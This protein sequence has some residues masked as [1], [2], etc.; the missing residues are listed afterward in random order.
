MAQATDLPQSNE[1]TSTG[2]WKTLR[3]AAAILA[4]LAI[5]YMLLSFLFMAGK[6][7]DGEIDRLEADATEFSTSHIWETG[8]TDEGLERLRQN[9]PR[10][11][12]LI[13]NGSSKISDRGVKIIASFENL[14]YLALQRFRNISESSLVHL[15]RLKNLKHLDLVGMPLTDKGLRSLGQ[16]RSLKSLYI[17]RVKPEQA[18]QLRAALP[19]CSVELWN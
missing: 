14:D 3:D 12:R 18:E 9:H 16:I 19:N 10:L 17:S 15:S 6:D 1:R 5:V 4:F 8:V 2:L 7:G 11:K 13:I